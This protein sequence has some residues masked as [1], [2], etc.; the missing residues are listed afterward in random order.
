[1]KT[2][3]GPEFVGTMLPTKT[4]EGNLFTTLLNE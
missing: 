1:M 2:I 4:F 3:I